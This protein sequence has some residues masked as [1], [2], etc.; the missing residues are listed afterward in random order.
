M[1]L[2]ITVLLLVLVAVPAW[3][4]TPAQLKAT[5]DSLKVAAATAD[6]LYFASLNAAG[7]QRSMALVQDYL[8]TAASTA[9]AKYKL[10][11][12]AFPRDSMY[13]QIRSAN[14][15]EIQLAKRSVNAQSLYLSFPDDTTA[16]CRRDRAMQAVQM[17]ERVAK[18]QF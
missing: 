5:A 11:V 12:L 6:S 17:L 14:S 4:A 10:K 2:S 16:V 7:A 9:K 3:A 15:V 18:G 1:K 13:V 8:D